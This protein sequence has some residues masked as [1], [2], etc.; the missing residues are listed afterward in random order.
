MIGV[1]ETT[2]A[3]LPLALVAVAIG[4]LGIAVACAVY[5]FKK[6]KAVEPKILADAWGY[7][8]AVSAFMGGPGRQAF[9]GVAW[10]DAHIVDGAVNGAGKVVQATAGEV[11]KAQSGNIRNYA[12]ALGVGVVLLLTWFIVVR[13]VL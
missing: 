10:A 9:E 7:D 12:A 1:H 13:G 2:T 4:L 11:R 6:V 5:Y 8:R 3:K